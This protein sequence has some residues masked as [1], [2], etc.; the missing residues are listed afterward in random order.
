VAGA[1]ARLD[2]RSA[3]L[4]NGASELEVLHDRQVQVGATSIFGE[5]PIMPPMKIVEG[6]RLRKDVE[7]LYL[8]RTRLEKLTALDLRAKIAAH[9]L[10]GDPC[11]SLSE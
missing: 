3:G 7:R 2:P 5:Q 11:G 9:R 4:E 10:E 6:G 8:R 1:L